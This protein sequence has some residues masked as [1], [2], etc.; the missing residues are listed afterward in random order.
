[1]CEYNTFEKD[2]I[3]RLIQIET[4]LKN[5]SDVF[6]YTDTF[7]LKSKKEAEMFLNAMN[8]KDI[9]SMRYKKNKKRLSIYKINFLLKKGVLKVDKDY[10]FNGKREWLFSSVS[11]ENFKGY[12]YS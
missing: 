10:K 4:L 3:Y 11:L 8:V 5:Y 7:D 6:V 9:H 1:M 12:K 2:V